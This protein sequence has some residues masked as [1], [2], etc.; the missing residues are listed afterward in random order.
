MRSAFGYILIPLFHI[1]II[2]GL[3]YLHA[4]RE[5]SVQDGFGPLVAEIKYRPADDENS[6]RSLASIEIVFDS[7]RFRFDRNRPIILTDGDIIYEPLTPIDYRRLDFGFAVRFERGINLE[8]TL[9]P[10]RPADLLIT[11]RADRPTPPLL[12]ISFYIAPQARWEQNDTPRSMLVSQKMNDYRLSMPLGSTVDPEQGIL[13]MRL[14][15]VDR[16][17]RYELLRYSDLRVI[18]TW[19]DNDTRFMSEERYTEYWELYR[20]VAY[21]GWQRKRYQGAS[22]KWLQ[23]NGSKYFSERLV[24]SLLAEAGGGADYQE[25]YNSMRRAANL[26]SRHISLLS[27]PFLGEIGTDLVDLLTN[28][29]KRI[30]Q[31]INLLASGDID[32]LDSSALSFYAHLYDSA[33]IESID[34][35]L[36]TINPFALDS[37]QLIWLL[38]ATLLPTI[39]NALA[40]RHFDRFRPLI[41]TILITR[42]VHIDNLPSY[43]AESQNTERDGFFILTK[44]GRVDLK[45]SIMAGDLLRRIGMAE[46][47]RRLASIGR[48]LIVSG[49]RFADND[50]FLPRSIFFGSSGLHGVS[51]TINPEDIYA[52]I[53]NNLFWPRAVQLDE[54][55]W[56]WT[57]LPTE[58]VES[59]QQGFI[60]RVSASANRTSYIIVHGLS[61][62]PALEVDNERWESATRYDDSRRG[63]R[64]IK[65]TGAVIMKYLAE[66][67]EA[68]IRVSY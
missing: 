6:S 24:V 55:R 10:Q 42:L 34:E 68:L 25:I 37:D 12:R 4:T 50:G 54:T 36:R 14:D 58:I 48:N 7:L 61:R 9:P 22:G 40:Q 63:Y 27:L 5:E 19:F 32:M 33:L 2:A 18:D 38:R 8:F 52:L 30:E 16:S 11:P 3:I 17:A 62:Q 60:V 21:E 41:E 29:R 67:D 45:L 28:E 44:S 31:S 43:Y 15:S 47:D 56:I 53:N 23:R 49:L 1:G 51:G 66:K 26:N 57:A 65:A 20:D 64:Y 59:S 13:A 46:Q 35:L 39:P